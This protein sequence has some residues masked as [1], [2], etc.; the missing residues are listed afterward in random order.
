MEQNLKF[1]K[2]HQPCPACQSSDALSVNEDG[3]AKCFSC[4]EFF[5]KGINN[6]SYT[7]SN[8]MKSKVTETVRELNA[9]G[10]VFAKLSDRNIAKETAEKYGVKVV[11]DSAGQLAQHIYPLYIN[12]ELTS[13]K[14]RYV[15]DKK[16]SF[17]VSPNGVGLFGQ[18]LFKGGGKYLTITEGECD[19]MAAYELLGSK[20]AVVSII[21]GAASAVKDI[22]ENLEYVESFDNIVLCFDK[23]K[24]GQEAAKKVATILKPGKA[25]IVTLPNGYKDA[26]D[27]L[28]KGSYQQFIS[29]WWDA[30]LYTPSGIIRVSEKKKEFLNREKKESVP[31]PWQGLNEKLY[32]LR[33]GEL[34]TLTGGTGLGKSSIT[35]ELEHWLVKQTQDNVGIIALEEDWRRTVDGVLSIEANARLY[36]DQER[37]KFDEDTLMNMFDKIFSNDKVFIHAHF[38]TNE[39]DDIFAKLRYLI[40]GCDCKWVVVDHLHMLVSALAEGDERRSIDNIMTRLRSLVEETGAGLILVSHLRRVD[41][42]KG[43]EN[44]IEV[45]LSHLR[46]SN[47]IGQLSDCVIAL[48]RN[49]QSDDPEEARTTKLRVLKSR[50]TGD[51]GMATSLI[52]DKETGRLSEHFDTEFNSEED[53]LTAF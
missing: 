3:S 41:G 51:V 44:G 45:S 8:N 2:Y 19:A 49:Q 24:Q 30:K 14:V 1:I 7:N 18:Q 37:E 35:R 16:F 46:G 21:R 9:H 10:G 11:Y 23:D 17:D 53:S 28:M 50:Y 12:N 38:G 26:N 42:N 47:S 43:H 29:A 20:W 40:V 52:Y 32:G 36:V 25:K 13:N 34:V 4:D 31:Y 27:M 48:E 33:Q 22:K 39:I 5:P 6:S 15:R